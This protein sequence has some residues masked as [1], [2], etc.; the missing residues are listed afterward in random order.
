MEKRECLA[1]REATRGAPLAWDR[2]IGGTREGVNRWAISGRGDA[3]RMIWEAPESGICGKDR[4][5]SNVDGVRGVSWEEKC[6]GMALAS[7]GPPPPV[8]SAECP[9]SFPMGIMGTLGGPGTGRRHKPGREGLWSLSV[10]GSVSVWSSVSPDPHRCP[11]PEGCF[12]GSVGEFFMQ[13]IRGG[14]GAGCLPLLPTLSLALLGLGNLDL[15]R[16]GRRGGRR[17]LREAGGEEG[18]VPWTL[19]PRWVRRGFDGA[20]VGRETPQSSVPWESWW[21][22]HVRLSGPHV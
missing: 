18:D 7:L 8:G 21:S 2:V 9:A 5:T 12:G 16:T 14:T 6:R 17:G 1:P 15:P 10:S 19:L 4:A 20:G 13:G 22:E 3:R 11:H